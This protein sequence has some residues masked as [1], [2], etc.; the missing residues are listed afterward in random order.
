MGALVVLFWRWRALSS[1]HFIGRISPFEMAGLKRNYCGRI[2]RAGGRHGLSRYYWP[3]L[4][5]YT[6]CILR[7]C[8]RMTVLGGGGVG[9]GGWPTMVYLFISNLSKTKITQCLS[10]T[11]W[12]ER[13][14]DPRELWRCTWQIKY[15][16]RLMRCQTTPGG[17]LLMKAGGHGEQLFCHSNP[18]IFIQKVRCN[19]A[20]KSV[21]FCQGGCSGGAVIKLKTISI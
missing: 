20:E 6:L 14:Q 16:I 4:Y 8:C 11:W 21:F 2:H 9:E 17:R 12:W 7:Y 1:L 18:S 13:L 19:Y 5:L 3:C 15:V 10:G